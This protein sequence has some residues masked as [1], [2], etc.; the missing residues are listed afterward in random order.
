MAR[1]GEPVPSHHFLKR[2]VVSA[3]PHINGLLQIADGDDGATAFPIGSGFDQRPQAR[4]LDFAGILKLIQCPMVKARIKSELQVFQLQAC[5]ASIRR[6]CEIPECQLPH[7]PR[8]GIVFAVNQRKEPNRSPHDL[9]FPHEI[10]IH[11]VTNALTDESR[12]LLAIRELSNLTAIRRPADGC[13]VRI[14]GELV[15]QKTKFV[16]FIRREER[17]ASIILHHTFH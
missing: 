15:Q 4:P 13:R 3:A 1:F 2:L 16:V 11:Q 10:D 9:K 14:A 7:P 8:R 6:I 5:T 12:T 17:L